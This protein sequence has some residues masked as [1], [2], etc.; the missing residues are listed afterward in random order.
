MDPKDIGQGQW[1]ALGIQGQGTSEGAKGEKDWRE[2]V[3]QG[4]YSLGS[5]LF[6]GRGGSHSLFSSHFSLLFLGSKSQAGTI[7]LKT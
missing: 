2:E 5:A 1:E 7:G 6:S 4:N 3:L